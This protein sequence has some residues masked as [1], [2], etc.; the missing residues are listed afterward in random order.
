M[1][2]GRSCRRPRCPHGPA[3]PRRNAMK[4]QEVMTPHTLQDKDPGQQ[5]GPR[6]G[7]RPHP[8][9]ERL[10]RAPPPLPSTCPDGMFFLCA[11]GAHV[12]LRLDRPWDAEGIL[13]GGLRWRRR[14]KRT[15]EQPRVFA[16][17]RIFS[18]YFNGTLYEG[19]I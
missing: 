18:I 19:L 8:A 12:F 15:A 17:S 3:P 1:Q 11:S 13:P 5:P 4:A 10:A 14:G 16:L 2:T 7:P 9:G 6:G